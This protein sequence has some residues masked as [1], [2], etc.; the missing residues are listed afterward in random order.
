MA[1]RKTV[2]SKGAESRGRYRSAAK[3]R[4]HPA[5]RLR[6]GAGAQGGGAE[7]EGAAGGAPKGESSGGGAGAVAK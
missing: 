6:P 3:L 1:G 4:H 2:H 7:A 5:A